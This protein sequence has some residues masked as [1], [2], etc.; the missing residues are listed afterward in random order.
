MFCMQELLLYLNVIF[1]KEKEKALSASTMCQ[2]SDAQSMV[3]LSH[4]WDAAG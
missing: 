2:A 3:S 1:W 4:C